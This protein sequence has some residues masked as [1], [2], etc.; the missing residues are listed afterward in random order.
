M[1]IE[2]YGGGQTAQSDGVR[3]QNGR[4]D[5]Q[6]LSDAATGVRAPHPRAGY[7]RRSALA[8]IA[9]RRCSARPGRIDS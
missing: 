3:V 7:A 1:G 8:S 2:E 9:S 4:R 6:E 5:Q